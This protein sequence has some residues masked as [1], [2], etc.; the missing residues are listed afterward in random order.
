MY[1]SYNAN[2]LSFPVK[3]TQK[4]FK[5]IPEWL[6]TLKMPS[7]IFKWVESIVA[8]MWLRISN[9][10]MANVLYK[11]PDDIP[12]EKNQSPYY[13]KVQIPLAFWRQLPSPS[14]TRSRTTM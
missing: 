7:F 4:Y 11:T 3:N 13:T 1:K 8:S 10:S 9:L 14:A 6:F 2:V 12:D 5:L